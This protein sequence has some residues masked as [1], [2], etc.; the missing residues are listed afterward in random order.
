MSLLDTPQPVRTVTG[1]VE[2][3]LGP[4]PNYQVSAAKSEAQRQRAIE[5]AAKRR[6]KRA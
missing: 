5:A 6:E 2:T 3:P 1:R 4:W